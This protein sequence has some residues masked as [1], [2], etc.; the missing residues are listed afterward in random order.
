ML[1][2][3][4]AIPVREFEELERI[5]ASLHDTTGPDLDVHVDDLLESLRSIKKREQLRIAR[6]DQIDQLA[7]R[8]R[9]LA[10]E[11]S[12]MATAEADATEDADEVIAQIDSAIEDITE[13]KRAFDEFDPSEYHDEDLRRASDILVTTSIRNRGR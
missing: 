4:I 1:T 10:D 5:V 8:L 7:L 11:V 2:P 12:D 13:A 6:A 9:E 3:M